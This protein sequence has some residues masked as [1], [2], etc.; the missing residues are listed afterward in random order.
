MDLYP[1]LYG[2]SA[3]PSPAKVGP[4]LFASNSDGVNGPIRETIKSTVAAKGIEKF[5]K[6]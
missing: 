2:G 5:N 6:V 3:E 1:F 4:K